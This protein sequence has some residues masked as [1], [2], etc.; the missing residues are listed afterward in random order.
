[1]AETYDASVTAPLSAEA[2]RLVSEILDQFDAASTEFRFPELGHGYY[3]AVD[4]RLHAYSDANRWAMIVE[5]IGYNPRGG[6]LYDVLHVFSNSLTTGRPGYEN[7][8]FLAVVDNIEEVEG[9]TETYRGA[10]PIVV[11]GHPLAVAAPAGTRLE[12]VFRE[13]TP[14]HRGLLLAD[15]SELRRRIPADL[16]EVLRLDDWHQPD[17]F[18]HRPSESET[19]RL[20]AEVLATADASR[21]R[22]KLP[23]NTHWSN[24]PDSGSL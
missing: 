3:F 24:W 13:L 22:P 20:L 7:E 14:E 5:A 16:P 8:D 19:Y 23:P 10:V 12:H 18:E 15:E 4:A 9:E 11:K 21:Y 1:M 17:L 6:N 2:G